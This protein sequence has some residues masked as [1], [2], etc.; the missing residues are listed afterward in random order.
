MREE[1]AK[2]ALEIDRRKAELERLGKLA[3]DELA[4]HTATLAALLQDSDQD[5]RKMAVETVG[6]LAPADL[7]A[8]YRMASRPLLLLL[9][10]KRDFVKTALDAGKVPTPSMLAS[11]LQAL[12]QEIAPHIKVAQ[13]SAV[14]VLR[15]GLT[16]LGWNVAANAPAAGSAPPQP[17]DVLG[18]LDAALA[19]WPMRATRVHKC[20]S[21]RAPQGVCP[22][23]G[24]TAVLGRP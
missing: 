23:R 3:P 9:A 15:S 10:S 20:G 24:S 1:K 14:T 16:T 11:F 21:P 5:V 4:T 8:F 22:F 18:F 6:K 7:Q 12:V 17:G 2:G 19:D 13:P